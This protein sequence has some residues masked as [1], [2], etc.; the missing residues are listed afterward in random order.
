MAL[1]VALVHAGSAAAKW[2]SG[3]KCAE[4]LPGRTC[5]P[6]VL[7]ARGAGCV[8]STS[9]HSVR[10]VS[11]LTC[12]HAVCVLRIDQGL[13]VYGFGAGHKVIHAGGHLLAVLPKA[14]TVSTGPLH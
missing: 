3:L 8:R 14:A 5:Q 4:T 9:T 6:C 12:I 13:L 1:A 7:R 11:G 10:S 2:R